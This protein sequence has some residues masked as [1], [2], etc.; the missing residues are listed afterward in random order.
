MML[1]RGNGAHTFVKVE[2]TFT[3]LRDRVSGQWRTLES[4]AASTA[5]KVSG[6]VGNNESQNAM[7]VSFTF[8]GEH[9]V[10]AVANI[11]CSGTARAEGQLTY[12]TTVTTGGGPEHEPRGWG[13]RLKA[14][15]GIEFESCPPIRYA[16]WT[17][18]RQQ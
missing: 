16:T 2:V 8:S 17:L 6:T 10:R 18:T 7:D 3:Q 1:D 13:I 12:N 5:G 4:T 11:D 9:P 14:F 15:N